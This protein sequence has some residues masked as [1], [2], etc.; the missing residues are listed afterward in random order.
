MQLFCFC[1]C[2][3][4]RLVG[5]NVAFYAQT[6]PNIFSFHFIGVIHAIAFQST[7]FF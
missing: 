3:S 1:L 4:V 2:G 7:F 5:V 6:E